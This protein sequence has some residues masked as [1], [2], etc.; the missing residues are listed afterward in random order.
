[1]PAWAE[2]FAWT[3]VTYFFAL[4]RTELFTA[5][6]LIRRTSLC[7]CLL[8]ADAFFTAK[9]NPRNKTVLADYQITLD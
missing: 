6:F 9:G 2:S 3:L 4:V 1:V 8:T 5:L 7:L